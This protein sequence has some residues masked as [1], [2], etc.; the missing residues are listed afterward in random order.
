MSLGLLA[1][2]TWVRMNSFIHQNEGSMNF[3]GC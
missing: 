3:S 1:N 2:G